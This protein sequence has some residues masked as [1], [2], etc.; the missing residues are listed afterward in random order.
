MK[1]TIKGVT[2]FLALFWAQCFVLFELIPAPTGSQWWGLPY[3]LTHFCVLI[4]YLFV[5]ILIAEGKFKK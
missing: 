2:I 4:I 5:T 3:Y 1:H